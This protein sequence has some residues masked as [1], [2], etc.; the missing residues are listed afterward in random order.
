MKITFLGTA[1]ANA[2]P[3]AFC[4]C[5]NCQAARKIGGKSFRKRSSLLLNDDLLIDFGPD[6]M[7]ASYLHGCPLTEVRYCLQTHAHE[8]HLDTSLLVSRAP[9]YEIVGA[10]HLDF[11]ASAKTLAL[12]AQR[13]DRDCTPF[14]LFDAEI[15]QRLDL[16]THE[17]R[18]HQSFAFGR[19]QVTAFPANH[20]PTVE[21]LLYA[22][23]SD[24]CSL[25]YG[26]DTATLPDETWQSLLEHRMCFDVVI[27]DHTY[28]PTS[29]QIDHLNAHQ[30][31]EHIAR[32]RDDG[33][34]AKNARIFATHISH[35]GN[36]VHPK[37][38][39]FASAN[40]YEIAYDG[41]TLDHCSQ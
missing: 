3:E 12:T 14:N 26:T 13:V 5:I 25:F 24:D 39:E 34:L 30:F 2:Y 28:G 35:S 17:V 22:I 8:D 32:F 41:L 21:P 40:G 20:D 23:Q 27:L 9:D 6:I 36:P 31:I 11:Y 7:S 29:S 15:E 18:G 38:V 1:S 37:L 19:Y 16:N 10:P 33:L 4:K